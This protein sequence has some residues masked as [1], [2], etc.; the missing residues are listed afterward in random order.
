MAWQGKPS[1]TFMGSSASNNY[2]LETPIGSVQ[3]NF[4]FDGANTLPKEV[5]LETTL[6]V[7]GFRQDIFEVW[8]T[9]Y[10]GNSFFVQGDC[11]GANYL[12]L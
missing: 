8:L 12:R 1:S 6:R 7:L 2:K 5:M 10:E 3:S 11:G 4:I 9:F